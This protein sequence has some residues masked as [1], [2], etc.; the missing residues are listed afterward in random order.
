[1]RS[2]RIWLTIAIAALSISSAARSAPKS[3]AVMT[4]DDLL[5]DTIRSDGLGPYEASFSGR[6]QDFVLSTG[7]RELFFDFSM[8]TSGP[9]D[10]P[11]EGEA[12]GWISGVT[13]TIHLLGNL[14]PGSGFANGTLEFHAPAPDGSGP[15]LWQMDFQGATDRVD[16]DL[17][18]EPDVIFVEGTLGN[19]RWWD[20]SKHQGPG[21]RGGRGAAT[22]WTAAGWFNMPW[23][24]VIER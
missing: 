13:L 4:F 14:A 3:P 17:D 8:P 12:A 23:G 7:K 20:G 2:G 19:L 21:G 24:A 15:A 16:V 18:G 5:G 9:G 22:G 11:F 6:D 1:M 10:T